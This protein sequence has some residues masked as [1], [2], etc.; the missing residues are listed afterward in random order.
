MSCWSI[1]CI[2]SYTNQVSKDDR[3]ASNVRAMKSSN[4]RNVSSHV[5]L[6]EQMYLVINQFTM[7]S[8]IREMLTLYPGVT[9][10]ITFQICRTCF[11]HRF[12]IYHQ[13]LKLRIKT[14]IIQISWSWLEFERSRN[15][16]LSSEIAKPSQLLAKV[17]TQDLSPT[18]KLMLKQ[19]RKQ[20]AM[21]LRECYTTTLR[22]NIE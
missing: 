7:F 9:M 5:A 10:G 14:K 12:N 17:Q 19:N 22:I 16:K 21:I 13:C 20:I 6:Q 8:K 15:D 3:I 4:I 18:L 2:Q 11:L 1:I